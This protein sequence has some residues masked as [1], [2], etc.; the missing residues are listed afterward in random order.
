MITIQLTDGTQTIALNGAWHIMEFELQTPE[1]KSSDVEDPTMAGGERFQMTWKNIDQVIEII[2]TGDLDQFITTVSQL[3]NMLGRAAERQSNI[4]LPRLYLQRQLRATDAWYRSEVVQG[5]VIYDS[6]LLH[7]PWPRKPVHLFIGIRRRFFWETVDEV[8]LGLSSFGVAKTTDPVTLYNHTD[9]AHATYVDI[10]AADV[11]GTL[12]TP[13]KITIKQL[14]AGTQWFTSFWFGRNVNANPT[15]LNHMLEAESSELVTQVPGAADFTNYSNGFGNS[16]DIT[17]TEN[18][19]MRWQLTPTFLTHANA[20]YFHVLAKLN[21][22]PLDYSVYSFFRLKLSVTTVWEGPK[23]FWRANSR[24]IDLGVIQLPPWLFTPEAPGPLTLDMVAANGIGG[25]QTIVFD[26]LSFVPT[27]SWLALNQL[28]YALQ[29]N[30]KIIY[31]GD[32][33][34]V[35][36]WDATLN[37]A[38]NIWT[39]QGPQVYLHPN[40]NQRFYLHWNDQGS[41]GPR[42]TG[43]WGI[44]MSYRPRRLTL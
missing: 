12:P 25:T 15:L 34:R 36:G 24:F 22:T 27:D 38:Y 35:Y 14:L 6:S 43:V 30:E 4:G 33:D 9:A 3:E 2:Y 41:G 16:R 5:R 31:D 40:K 17:G 10:V 19:I 28:G 21:T 7:Y 8:A 13:P 18:T 37:Q 39:R 23:M 42:M 11:L 44:Q 26:F 32:T 20:Q 1:V 29:Q